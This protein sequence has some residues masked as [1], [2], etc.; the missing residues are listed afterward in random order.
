M[1]R[2]RSQELVASAALTLRMPAAVNAAYGSRSMTSN[3]AP[4]P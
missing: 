1:T 4:A 3:T 2:S